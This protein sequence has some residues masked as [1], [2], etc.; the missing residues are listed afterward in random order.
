MPIKI[1]DEIK[2]ETKQD[3]KIDFINEFINK[4]VKNYLSSD[5][6]ISLYNNNGTH[7]EISNIIIPFLS[8]TIS[9]VGNQIYIYNDDIKVHYKLSGEMNIDDFL[10][11][12]IITYCDVSLSKISHNQQNLIKHKKLSISSKTL[13]LMKVKLMIDTSYFNN[14]RLFEIHFRDGYID[15]RTNEFKQRKQSDYVSYCIMRSIKPFLADENKKQKGDA[16]INKILRQIYPQKNDFD[17]IMEML[18]EAI[19]GISPKSQRNLFLLG[20]GSTGKS[21][22]MEILG[23]CFDK[24]ILQLKED[25]LCIHNQ[26]ADRI[27]NMLMTNPFIRIYY[28]NEMK[29]KIDDSKF[30]QLCDGK[31]TTT[32][33]FQEGMNTV[34]INALFC[35][36]MNEFPKVKIDSGVERRITSYEHT[37]NF[38]KDEKKVKEEKNIYYANSNLLT[39]LKDDEDALN[40]FVAMICEYAFEYNKGKRYTVPENFK[41]TKAGIIDSNDLIKTFMDKYLEKTNNEKDILTIDEIYEN[42]KIINPKSFITLQQFNGSIKEKLKH[43][44]Y[45]YNR[46]IRKN[47]SRG[48]Y[49]KIKFSEINDNSE[50]DHGIDTDYKFGKI[51]LNDK[52]KKLTKELEDANNEIIL[53]KEK[54]KIAELITQKEDKKEEVKPPINTQKEEKKKEEEEE[55]EEEE[56]VV[57][58]PIYRFSKRSR[59]ILENKE[60][61]TDDILD[62]FNKQKFLPEE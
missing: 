9:I 26:K 51:E 50:L 39:E 1:I 13:N 43:A 21:T 58:K 31:I 4:K 12:Y 45:E 16:T 56:E 10:L 17:Y 27:L 60:R 42:F 37:S 2:E 23:L 19:L 57:V 15:M 22:I 41:E 6:V 20:M 28:I 11:S 54:L 38:V 29:G 35:V 3:I 53:L 40:A 7:T 61:T 30:K 62:I 49:I 24:M 32:T 33:L 47:G 36:I 8:Q 5:D 48:C 55:E 14:P 59:E 46:N 18:A 44:E 52:I 34:I 25:T